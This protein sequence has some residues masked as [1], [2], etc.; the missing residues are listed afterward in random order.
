MENIMTIFNKV[1]KF[2]VLSAAAFSLCQ[3]GDGPHGSELLTSQLAGQTFGVAV[4]STAS[5]DCVAD[6][7]AS[8]SDVNL[9]G[10]VSTFDV[11]DTGI[12]AS[13]NRDLCTLTDSDGNTVYGNWMAMDENTISVTMPDGSEAEFNVSFLPGGVMVWSGSDANCTADDTSTDGGTSTDN[14]DG[15]IS[16]G[17]DTS[18]TTGSTT[19]TTASIDTDGDGVPDSSDAF[20]TNAAETTDTDGDGIGDNADTDVNGDGINDNPADDTTTDPVTTDTDG[21]G[22]MDSDDAFPDDA[23]ETLDTDGDGIGNNVDTDDDGDGV[24]DEND[25]DPID[26]T[27]GEIDTDGDGLGV[28]IDPKDTVAND[29]G[30]ID[31]DT[32]TPVCLAEQDEYSYTYVAGTKGFVLNKGIAIGSPMQ[33]MNLQVANNGIISPTLPMGGGVRVTGIVDKSKATLDTLACGGISLVTEYGYD[34][35]EDFK[36]GIYILSEKNGLGSLQISPGPIGPINI[37][38]IHLPN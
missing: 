16:I 35:V 20:P 38:G 34:S 1:Q 18:G 12:K 7:S 14:G 9:D 2:L 29:W 8:L 31:F 15:N 10:S 3:C 24:A 37:G 25:S 26:K 23:T 4:S 30:Y 22:V 5:A 6:V 27:K 13:F 32:G 11:T 21:D 36:Y 33:T 28:T 19:T 17:G